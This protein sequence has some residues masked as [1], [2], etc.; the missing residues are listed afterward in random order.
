M[1]ARMQPTRRRRPAAGGKSSTRTSCTECR[2]RRQRCDQKQPCGRCARRYPPPICHYGDDDELNDRG[3]PAP[4]TIIRHETDALA[5]AHGQ[6]PTFRYEQTRA[7]TRLMEL[8]RRL[9]EA[10]DDHENEVLHVYVQLHEQ[11]T[12]SL[13]TVSD[14]PDPYQRL[15]LPLCAES[16][17]L[18]QIFLY[19]GAC[20]LAETGRLSPTKVMDAKGRAIHHLN[21]ALRDTAPT[22]GD[23]VIVAII[24]I[25]NNELCHGTTQYLMVHLRG[26][27]DTIQQYG[28]LDALGMRGVLAKMAI[29]SD[30]AAALALETAPL[31]KDWQELGTLDSPRRSFRWSHNTPLCTTLPDFSVCADMMR[32]HP[33]TAS[34]LDDMRVLT[35]LVLDHSRD[36]TPLKA[37]KLKSTTIWLQNRIAELPLY[38]PSTSP[39][40]TPSNIIS[41]ATPQPRQGISP[42]VIPVLT[43]DP[44][45]GAA[46]DCIYQ[47]VRQTALLFCRTVL[48]RKHVRSVILPA[49]LIAL[50]SVMWRV[51]LEQW[52]SILGVFVWIQTIIA[53]AAQIMPP[54]AAVKSMFP[55]SM[56][57]LGTE[58]WGVAKEVFGN[59]LRIQEWLRTGEDESPR[60]ESAS[61][62]G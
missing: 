10:L 40:T 20:F 30:L 54:C 6:P 18:S 22:A 43:P 33:T 5:A 2:R 56:G 3:I 21:V 55:L 51:E 59:S 14:K 36:P 47:C 1:Y 34:I 58:N 7:F 16:P 53:P 19:L 39:E 12:S 15:I 13:R 57:Q 44:P 26:L 25:I 27:R 48:E 31:L 28:G 24:L 62:G 60:D 42:P 17:L 23:E 52:G 32:I 11:H 41:Q 50:W 4:S 29:T 38:A 45:G 35:R 37:Q 9:P 8:A 46:S 49:D 61:E